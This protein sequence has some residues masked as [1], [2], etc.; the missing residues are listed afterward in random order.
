MLQTSRKFRSGKFQFLQTHATEPNALKTTE[1]EVRLFTETLFRGSQKSKHFEIEP[2]VPSLSILSI[3]TSCRFHES[4]WNGIGSRF[5]RTRL[6]A[7]GNLVPRVFSPSSDPGDIQLSPML[8]SRPK[9]HVWC[10]Y[11]ESIQKWCSF[12]RL[13][14]SDAWDP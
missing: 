8:G 6:Q 14:V 4:K 13:I 2:T 1:W 5:T 10:N 9:N 7:T 12:I 11:R 3:I